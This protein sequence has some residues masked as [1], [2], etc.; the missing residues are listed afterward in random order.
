MSDAKD[1]PLVD[2]EQKEHKQGCC[3]KF[4]TTTGL[5]C[6]MN[7]DEYKH[8]PLIEVVQN[9]DRRCT[10]VPCCLILLACVISELVLIFYAAEQGASPD[11]LMYG[12]D[13]RTSHLCDSSNAQGS[14]AIW[15]VL[16]HSDIRICAPDCGF[17][18]DSRHKYIPSIQDG[19]LEATYSSTSFMNAYCLPTGGEATPEGFTSSTQS[20]QRA[21]SDLRTTAWLIFIMAFVSIIISFIFVKL[22]ACIGPMLIVFTIIVVLVGGI[23]ASWLL[24]EQGMVEVES[25]ETKT[26]GQIQIV[27]G[28]I[29]AV[30]CVCLVL[31]LWFMRKNVELVVEM[32]KEASYAIRDM[33]WTLS[34]PIFISFV[35]IC[36]IAVWIIEALYIYSVKTVVQRDWPSDF[37]IE[38]PYYSESTYYSMQFNSEMQDSMI[39][40]WIMLFYFSQIII[41]FG[42][43][44]LSGTFAD[45]YFSLWSDKEAK[46]KQRGDGPA[47]L[48]N[49]PIC[50]SFWRVLRFHLGSLAFGAMIIAII[51]IIRAIVT[52]IQSKVVASTN[53]LLKCIFC[54][55]QCCLWC[56]QCIFDKINKEGFIFTTVYGTAYCY[57]SFTALSVL[58]K[59]LARFAMIEGVSSYTECFAR[60]AIASLTTGLTVLVMQ[61]E[62]YYTKNVSS[63]LFPAIVVFVMSYMIAAVFMMVFEVAVDTI[64]LCFLVDEEVHGGDAK[65]ANHG[66]TQMANFA[67][68]SQSSIQGYGS[69]APARKQKTES[70][71]EYAA[72]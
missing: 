46:T 51:R 56:C 24:I 9:D 60:I 8:N 19:P 27:A 39:W 35:V 7:V 2:E 10:D 23:M 59:N 1:K 62:D 47:E 38:N 5:C 12:F 50:E 61:Y 31:A 34:F 42:Y 71:E 28:V 44:V 72:I 65:F 45:W 69:G 25:E 48:S 49:S 52:Y 53:P 63:F 17:T 11:V 4:A 26:V 64:F 14:Y 41:Y 21:V 13:A 15:P 16:S 67:A 55:V 18:N 36:F 3:D 20:F 32:L 66:L 58:S 29:L 54:C 40:H 43:M 30:L 33:K 70:I 57:S 37:F 22:I 6:F 68:K